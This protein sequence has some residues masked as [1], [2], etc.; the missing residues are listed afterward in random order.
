MEVANSKP[1]SYKRDGTDTK[2]SLQ[3]ITEE[4]EDSSFIHNDFS[5]NRLIDEI[6]LA[7]KEHNSMK[8]GDRNTNFKRQMRRQGT[9]VE[10]MNDFNYGMTRL[11]TL[12][13]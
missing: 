2:F 7:E 4:S 11:T 5:S 3:L 8:R 9:S 6:L 13:K 12:K 1:N 10:F